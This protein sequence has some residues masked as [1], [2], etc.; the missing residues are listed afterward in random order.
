[1]G[2][3]VRGMAKARTTVPVLPLRG[4]RLDRR[5]SGSAAAGSARR[6]APSSEVGVRRG[7]GTVRAGPVTAPALP[8]GAGRRSRPRRPGRTGVD[9]LDRVLGGG[10][11]PGAVVLLAGEPGR[12]Q[13]DAAAGG[14]GPRGR[15]GP[16]RA[17]RDGRG[18]GRPGAAAGRPH[19]RA[20]RRTCSSPPRPTCPPCSATSTTSSRACS[21]STPC[22]RSRTS[23]VDGAAGGVTQVREVAG[24]LIRRRQGARHR[25][26][27]RR[28]RH[29]GRLDR[30]PAH[31]RAPRRRGAALRGRPALAAAAGPGA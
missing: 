22:R 15:A 1:M 28:P 27:A 2:R 6:G 8:I 4:V 30:R 26:R 11:V 25:D 14:R 7:C 9:E 29:Q 3:T 13:V 19:R 10:L 20:R 5:P 31:S 17:V 16:P 12:R 18:V 21:S 23:E 24:A